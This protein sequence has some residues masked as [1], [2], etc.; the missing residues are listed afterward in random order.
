MREIRIPNR[1]VT[2]T[3]AV[4]S[5]F[6]IDDCAA[7][8]AFAVDDRFQGHGLGALLLEQLA[9]LAATLGFTRFDAVTQADNAA[10]LDMLR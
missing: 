1:G 5:Y 9:A 4:G 2:Q 7:E 3:I 6:R 10:M 8:V